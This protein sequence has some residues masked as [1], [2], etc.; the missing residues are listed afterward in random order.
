M[1][2]TATKAPKRSGLLEK[3]DSLF[4]GP[5]MIGYSCFH[6]WR[7]PERLMHPAEVVIHEVGCHGRGVI[8][9][10]FREGVRQA[11][12]PAHLTHYPLGK[13]RTNAVLSGGYGW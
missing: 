9:Q 5:N 2:T 3:A 10:L 11:R 1:H 12:E 4:D 13:M 6:C 8:L 7:H